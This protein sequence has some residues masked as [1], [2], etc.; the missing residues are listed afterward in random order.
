[1]IDWLGIIILLAYLSVI[2]F[3]FGISS[4]LTRIIMWLEEYRKDKP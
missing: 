4:Q 2:L 1:M 3:L